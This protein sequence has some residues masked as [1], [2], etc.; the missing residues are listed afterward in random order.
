M[1]LIETKKQSLLEHVSDH[2][3]WKKVLRTRTNVLAVFAASEKDLKGK[4]NLLDDVAEA[5]RGRATIVAVNC[6]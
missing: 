5:M 1:V 2:K 6:G 3:E 4:M